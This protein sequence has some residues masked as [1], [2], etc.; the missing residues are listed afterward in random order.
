M[1]DFRNISRNYKEW[2]NINWWEVIKVFFPGEADEGLDIYGNFNKEVSIRISDVRSI[3]DYFAFFSY[4][5]G[6]SMNNCY[7]V[8]RI[9]WRLLLKIISIFAMQPLKISIHT[10]Y[11][12]QSDNRYLSWHAIMNLM[13]L[14]KPT[15]EIY[16]NRKIL[17]SWKASKASL[18]FTRL[19]RV[20]AIWVNF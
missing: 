2:F 7:I 15:I 8:W 10:R 1:K 13:M 14:H 17:T 16:K 9:V 19:I 12:G 11:S 18:T 4:S 3:T 20:L 6:N 5:S